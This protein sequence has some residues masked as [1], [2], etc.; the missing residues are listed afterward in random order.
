MKKEQCFIPVPHLITPEMQREY[1]ESF[2][3]TPRTGDM[4]F[5]NCLVHDARHLPHPNQIAQLCEAIY[6]AVTSPTGVKSHIDQQ[7]NN[8]IRKAVLIVPLYPY[9]NSFKEYKPTTFYPDS[10]SVTAPIGAPI[11]MDTT[12]RHGVEDNP[13]IDQRVALQ[14]SFDHKYTYSDIKNLLSL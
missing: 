5:V 4:H 9:E 10:G 13:N 7:Y 3:T 12:V 11:L 1:Y 8:N 6:F 2:T 14:F